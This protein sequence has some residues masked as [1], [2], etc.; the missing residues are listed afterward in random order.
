LGEVGFLL[1]REGVGTV[2]DEPTRHFAYWWNGC[3][4]WVDVWG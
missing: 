2:L 1:G 4:V 3:S